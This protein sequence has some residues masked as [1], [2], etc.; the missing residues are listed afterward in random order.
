MK[1]FIYTLHY[2][3]YR[4]WKQK[5]NHMIFFKNTVMFSVKKYIDYSN[6]TSWLEWWKS[7]LYKYVQCTGARYSRKKH[8][9][10][11]ISQVTVMV[12]SRYC[13][14]LRP[15]RGF[16]IVQWEYC[17]PMTSLSIPPD[18]SLL[19]VFFKIYVDECLIYA[20]FIIGIFYKE[21]NKK[22][23]YVYIY[24]F[25]GESESH[26]V[27][28]DSLWPHG[29]CSLCSSPGQ[30]TGVGILFLL[31]GIFPI[32]GLNPSLPYIHMF[33]HICIYTYKYVLA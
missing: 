10:P 12:L 1:L 13:H 31:Q 24:I 5:K 27:M 30:N 29:L 4:V 22:F 18:L 11:R 16:S 7:E 20:Y 32:Q 25:I 26:S 33:V 14:T 19:I 28:S 2:I 15:R 21:W 9:Y 17:T 3:I 23:F 8:Q 6:K